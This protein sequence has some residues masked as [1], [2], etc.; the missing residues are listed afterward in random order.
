MQIRIRPTATATAWERLR[1]LHGDREPRVAQGFLTANAWAT[2]TGGQ[3]DDDHDGYG[4]KC[5]ADFTP[6]GAIVGPADLAQFRTSEGKSRT[7]DT[8]GLPGRA[9]ARS[10]IWTS[11]RPST[12]RRT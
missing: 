2:L 11:F 8:C 6:T 12:G 7:V 3:R 5:D 10:S 4:N 1:Q 9:P